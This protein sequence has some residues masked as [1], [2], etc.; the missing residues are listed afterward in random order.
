MTRT[1]L[2]IFFSFL[3][4]T[5]FAQSP[6]REFRAAWIATV[7]NI[8]WPSKPGLPANQ[9]QQE[10]IRRLDQLQSVGCNAVIVQVRPAADAF[11]ES[12]FEPW[13]RYLTGKQGLPP[14]PYYDPLQFM[15]NE[16]HKRNMEF[17]AWFNPYRVLTD[18]KK[19]PNPPGHVS[20]TH[21][22]WLISYGGKTQ[23][24]PGI[25]EVREYVLSIIMDVVKRYD[26]DAVH[27]DDYFYPYRIAGQEF[28]DAKSYAR[29][30][31]NLTNKDDW[32]RNNVSMFILALH[33][34]VRAV[35]PYVKIGISPFGVWRNASKDPE[36]S[37]TRG[38]Q[39]N[40]DDLYAD[41]L[42]WMKKGWIDYLLPQLYWEHGH[43]AAAF[44]VLLPWWERHSYGRHVYYGLGLYR[45]VDATSGVWSGTRELL[46]QIHDIRRLANNPGYSLYSSS[47]FDKIR[48][49]IKDSLAKYTAYPA[50][51][52]QM[53]WLDSIAPQPPVL[54][55]AK[56]KSG[57]LLEWK[58]PKNDDAVCF[59]VY[60]F[61]NN[62]PINLERT[63]RIIKVQSAP[64]L[65][66]F[67]MDDVPTV[68]YAVTAFDR[69]WNESPPSNVI[70]ISRK[71]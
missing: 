35:K 9:Q 27:L 55:L 43:R 5:V 54:K 71:H 47:N 70:E 51:P 39:T 50:F 26:I 37:P 31:G 18:S 69:L 15:I 3:V 62:E 38:G 4:Q 34:Q 68:K 63:D 8:D 30:K 17:H 58:V 2:I 61:I 29:Y 56:S 14:S 13:S 33:N 22:D 45:M 53:K 64:A 52:P 32:R 28:G 67:N 25:P 24:D 36:G 41:V 60:K 11:Y 12:A 44:E 66:D 48:V 49:P 1:S 65:L 40:Y 16:T 59:A 42:F 6:K 57:N 46:S 23:F 7:S 19:N 21:P 10:F 20:R